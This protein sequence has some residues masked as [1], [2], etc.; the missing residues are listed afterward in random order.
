MTPSLF[1]SSLAIQYA[2]LDV[3]HGFGCGHPE[4]NLRFSVRTNPQIIITLEVGALRQHN[5]CLT[6]YLHGHGVYNNKQVKALQLL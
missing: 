3:I 6:G 1:A 5:I 4:G 2:G